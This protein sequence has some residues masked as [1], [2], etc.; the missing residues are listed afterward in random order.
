M[1]FKPNQRVVIER[2]TANGDIGYGTVRGRTNVSP[3]RE[4]GCWSV[5]VDAIKGPM[6][7]SEDRLTDEKEY[8]KMVRER[9]NQKDYEI[10]KY[11]INHKD[12]LK[13]F[14]MKD[15]VA[16]LQLEHLYRDDLHNLFITTYEEFITKLLQ[17][18]IMKAEHATYEEVADIFTVANLKKLLG[19]DFFQV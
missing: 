1:K 6:I 8:I 7:V 17:N 13:Q 19:E 10:T 11:L 5:D 2:C 9:Y 4:Q 15:A 14:I 3:W 12:G 16:F 18:E